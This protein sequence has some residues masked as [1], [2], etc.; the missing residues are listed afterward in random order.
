[1]KKRCRTHRSWAVGAIVVLALLIVLV[2]T[3]LLVPL[4]VWDVQA[5]GGWDPGW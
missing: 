1:M 3:P 2:A 5:A 4:Y